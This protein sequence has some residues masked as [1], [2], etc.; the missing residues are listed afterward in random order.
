VPRFSLATRARR[1]DHVERDEDV[2]TSCFSRLAVLQAQYGDELPYAGVLSEGFAFRGQR[3]PFLNYQKGIYRAAV[4]RGPA[5]LSIQTSARSPYADE[6]TDDGFFYDYR[7]GSI[8]QRDNRA[9]RAAAE[10]GVPI[11]YFVATRPGW[12]RP[13][14]PYFVARDLPPEA[15]VLVAPGKLIGAFDEPEPVPVGD[16]A[17]RRYVVRETKIRLHQG[18]FRGA[19]LLAYRDQCAICRLREIRL[20]DAAHIEPDIAPSGEPLVANGLSMCTIHHRAFDQS[21]VGISPDYGVHVS[22]RLL[23]DEDGPMLEV[24][25]GFDGQTIHL[26]ARR[27]HYPDRERL[28]ARYES[29]R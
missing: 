28:A 1:I 20:L 15:R 26:P 2:R 17:E 5:A 10:L 21:L 13:L 6:E 14:Y 19:V 18:R 16:V 25:K 7:E 3:I 22:Q 9:L 4:Q 12:Y 23:D 11:V 24:L 27:A 8:D 29:F